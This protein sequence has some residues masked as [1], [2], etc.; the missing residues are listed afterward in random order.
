ME[1]G[2][3]GQPE[4]RTVC[5]ESLKDTVVSLPRKLL[6]RIEHGDNDCLRCFPDL[7]KYY[8]YYANCGFY[9]YNI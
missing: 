1:K 4:A 7:I 3:N 5:H 8:Y 9:Q 2:R 6:E